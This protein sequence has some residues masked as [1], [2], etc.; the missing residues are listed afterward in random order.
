MS[1]RLPDFLDPWHFADVGKR[2]SGTVA[3]SKLPRLAPYLK[4]VEGEA[5]FDLT[6]G[7]DGRKRARISGNVRTELAL[8]CQRCLGVLRYSVDTQLE[9]IVVEGIDEAEQLPDTAEPLLMEEAQLR[10]RDLVED[11]L[12]LALPQVAMH[13]TGECA[14]ASDGSGQQS[15]IGEQK[16]TTEKASPFAQ[17]AELKTKQ[18]EE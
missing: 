13:K 3:L 10:L 6:F 12:L 4:E 8:E 5:E 2:I 14:A 16:S 15:E 17:L 7:R 18:I 9:L 1:S 11:E